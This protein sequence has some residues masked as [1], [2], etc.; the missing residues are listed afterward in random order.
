MIRS[1]SIY[2]HDQSSAPFWWLLSILFIEVFLP[3]PIVGILRSL[4]FSDNFLGIYSPISKLDHLKLM[5]L[6]RSYF[7]GLYSTVFL[8]SCLR[9]ASAEPL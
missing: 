9:R 8:V 6:H 2:E 5:T 3:S 7:L 4:R 1:V